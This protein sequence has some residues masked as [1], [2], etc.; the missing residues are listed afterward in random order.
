MEL[1]GKT[2]INPFLFYSGKTAGYTTWI[3]YLLLISGIDVIEVH[4]LGYNAY[5]S[6][7]FGIAGLLFATLSLINLGNSTRLGLPS[8]DTVL[9][10][11]GIYKISRNPMYV[12]FNLL[13][14]SSVIYTLNLLIIVIGIYSI[15]IYHLIIL[16]E[17]RFLKNKFGAEYIKY[18]EKTRRYI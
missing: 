17:E 2:T 15:I 18:L 11:K 16:G 10:T 14:I 9:K 13:T 4:V 5:S 7:A 1:I 6:Y 3:I 8:S 12:G